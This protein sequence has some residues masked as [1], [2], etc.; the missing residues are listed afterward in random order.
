LMTTNA[1][2]LLSHQIEAAHKLDYGHQHVHSPGLSRKLMLTKTVEAYE[3]RDLVFYNDQKEHLLDNDDSYLS[4]SNAKYKWPDDFRDNNAIQECNH[5]AAKEL[6]APKNATLA[7]DLMAELHVLLE[8]D[9]ANTMPNKAYMEQ[10][11]APME[12][13]KGKTHEQE[14]PQLR[15]GGSLVQMKSFWKDLSMWIEQRIE[16]VYLIISKLEDIKK[17]LAKLLASKRVMI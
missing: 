16:K 4:I 2:F 1:A 5:Y 11:E 9:K 15:I 7:Q 13:H 10:K 14:Q 17:L 8:Q 3:D 6:N 12:S